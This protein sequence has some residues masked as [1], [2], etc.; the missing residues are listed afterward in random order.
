MI[1]ARIQTARCSLNLL[2]ACSGNETTNRPKGVLA[3]TL[4][5]NE[6]VA[7]MQEQINRGDEPTAMD[8]FDPIN[9]TDWT[10]YPRKVL[11]NF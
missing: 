4:K 3:V 1:F 5:L 6:K 8:D 7:E 2:R 10:G 11:I 9:D